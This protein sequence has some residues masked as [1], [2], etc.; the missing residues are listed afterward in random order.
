MKTPHISDLMNFLNESPTSFQAAQQIEKKLVSK[1][2]TRLDETEAWTIKPGKKYYVMRNQSAVIAFITG[3]KKPSQT[4]FNLSA[5]HLDSPG[6]KIK[7]G[8]DKSERNNT[9]LPVE[10]YGGPIISTWLDRELSIAGRVMVKTKTVKTTQWESRLVNLKEPVAIIP[11]VAIHLNR[12]VN[13]GFEYNAQN[14]L[15]AIVQAVGNNQKPKSFKEILAESLKVK[16]EQIGAYDLFLYDPTPVGRTGADKEMLVSGRLDNLGMS[17]AILAAIA[18]SEPTETTSVAIFY[19]NEEISSMTPEG[20]DSSFTSDILQRICWAQDLSQEETLIA[21]RKSFLVSA[22]MANALH[23]N[24]PEKY[25]SA[26]VTMLNHGPVIKMNAGQRYATTADSSARFESVCEKAK[27]PVQRIINR[28]D[29]ISGMTIGPITS[30]RLSIRTIDVGN[31]MW[32]MHSVRE[33]MGVLD[34]EYLIQALL[35]YYKQ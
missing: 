20:A 33:T 26:F 30:S 28:S 7:C 34:H 22:D 11:N 31:P 15:Q 5:S 27:V 3:K 9:K 32:A 21:F 2:F 17:H 23:P 10:L 19:D 24:F 13:K 14:H 29:S 12:E 16:P 4:G 1:G 18:E 8:G 25:D 6:L 35:E